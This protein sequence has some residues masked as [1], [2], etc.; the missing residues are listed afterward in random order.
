MPNRFVYLL[1]KYVLVRFFI[2]VGFFVIIGG[3]ISYIQ[4]KN[5]TTPII[6][7][8]NPKIFGKSGLVV[9]SGFHFGKT[10][11]DS[12][13]K[14]DNIVVPSTLCK[15]WEDQKIVVSADS[16]GEGGLLFVIT[17]NSYSAPAFI[18]HNSNIPI[19]KMQEA[20]TK[21]PSIEALSR[22]NG[23]IGQLIKIYGANFGN[24]KENSEVIFWANE[25]PQNSILLEKRNMEYSAYC[26]EKDFDFEF[27][28][29]EEVHIRIPDFASSGFLLMKT[30]YGL[31]NAIP[32]NIKNNVGTKILT[33]KKTFTFSLKT[34]VSSI[35]GEDK[36]TLFLYTPMPEECVQQGNLLSLFI[37][38]EPLIQNYNGA[39]VHKMDDIKENEEVEIK[40]QYKITTYDLTTNIKSSNIQIK[41]ISK[42]L[43]NHYT[44]ET[45]LLPCKN[46]KI[47]NVAHQIVKEDKNPYTRAYKIYQHITDNFEINKDVV[48]DRS[49]DVLSFLQTKRGSPY[50]ASLLFASLCRALDIPSLVAS[51][52]VIDDTK[53]SHIHWWNEFYI[54]G[55]GWVPVDL[56]MALSIPYRKDIKNHHQYYFGSVDNSRIIFSRGD[57]Q[58]LKMATDSKVYSH[59]RSFGLISFWEEACNINSYTC[60]WHVPQI[61]TIN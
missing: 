55:F 36:N 24:T 38:P 50:D 43:Y 2:L 41:D 39:T 53:K 44:D 52:V 16:L 59:E 29:D 4:T 9:I 23:E 37:Q 21:I 48:S 20:T 42:K 40:H 27:W 49:Q 12:F 10:A 56:G 25:E 47:Q 54:Q 33:N 34:D 28:S 17:G 51:G 5:K 22:D 60:F 32:F 6:S 58:I 14:I 19:V 13:L 26:S 18:S 57:R 7:Q 8:I 46:I 3:G 15:E 45:P 1:Q 35:K 61:I 31:S 11:D 30:K